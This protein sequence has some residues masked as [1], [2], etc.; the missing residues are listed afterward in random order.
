MF[1]DEDFFDE[2]FLD[3]ATEDRF[4]RLTKE[5]QEKFMKYFSEETTKE[6]EKLS[7]D[8]DLKEEDVLKIFNE[9]VENSF[10]AAGEEKPEWRGLPL[11]W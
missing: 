3:E 8:K 7:K 9:M 4:N 2:S 5:Q 6:L 10:K 1:S 11:L